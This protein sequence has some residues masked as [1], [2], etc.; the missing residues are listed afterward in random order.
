MATDTAVT[1]TFTLLWQQGAGD[2]DDSWQCRDSGEN[3][4]R[5][6]SDVSV[7]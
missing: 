1:T 4:Q 7:H 5:C 3:W 6:D 2:S